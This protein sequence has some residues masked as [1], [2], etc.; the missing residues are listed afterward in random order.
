MLMACLVSLGLILSSPFNNGEHV[1]GEGLFIFFDNSILKDVQA[2]A[3]LNN[4]RYEFR[5]FYH[6][7]R[8]LWMGS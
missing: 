3:L 1:E 7:I 6:S 5:L 4:M 2:Y 8:F